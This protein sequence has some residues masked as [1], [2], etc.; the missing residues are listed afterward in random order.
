MIKIENLSFK[1]PYGKEAIQNLSLHI[2][3]HKKVAIAGP[4]GSGKSTL[5]KLIG[6]LIK[7]QT[8]KI[9]IKGNLINH[10]SKETLNFL[11]RTIGILFQEADKQL[12]GPTVI[13]DVAFGLL[14]RDMSQE[15]ARAKSLQ[16]LKDFNI[17]HLAEHPIHQLSGGEKRLVALAGIMVSSPEL[18]LLDEPTAS[19]D[20]PAK[21]Q[22]MKIL[23]EIYKSG[24]TII[25]ASHDTNFITNWADDIIIL[26]QGKIFMQLPA[27]EMLLK[28]ERLS[29]VGIEPPVEAPKTEPCIL[30]EVTKA[31][32]HTAI[33]FV[34]FGTSNKIAFQTYRR[35]EKF[36][37]DRFPSCDIYWAFTSKTVLKKVKNLNSL[38][39][40]LTMLQR[41]SKN[42]KNYTKLIVL[43]LFVIRGVEYDIFQQD[44]LSFLKTNHP[45]FHIITGLPLL[46][47]IRDL[48]LTAN[49]IKEES[50]KFLSKEDECA[51]WIG[52]GSKTHSE[53]EMYYLLA[54]ELKKQN[55]RIFIELVELKEHWHQLLQKLQE[56]NIKKAYLFPFMIVAG[57]HAEEDINGTNSLRT[58]LENAGIK[59]EYISKG[60]G[61]YETF[62]S[63]WYEHIASLINNISLIKENK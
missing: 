22:F 45:P 2:R 48:S 8:G 40:Q 50:E 7:P 18:I 12:I 33:L 20:Y 47:T 34:G 26:K 1:Y 61:D 36:F 41:M 19:L 38:P 27:C 53:N 57:H 60:L 37:F 49:A 24:T 15:K 62:N 4:N 44:I 10:H 21:L 11:R 31:Y 51:I 35:I 58:L 46:S 54:K 16:I 32:D 13:E 63:I 9:Y 29:D 43:P 39:E 5:L 25:I 56:Q 23:Q 52:H 17:S 42:G 14:N 59:C 6:G 55:H 30:S 28:Q 3:A